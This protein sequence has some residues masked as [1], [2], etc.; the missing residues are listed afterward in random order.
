[1][2]IHTEDRVRVFLEFFERHTLQGQPIKGT[3]DE[4]P[5]PRIVRTEGGEFLLAERSIIFAGRFMFS[6]Y[7]TAAIWGKCR[8]A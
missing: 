3:P 1:M 6:R 2:R 8:K 7:S 4:V 5:Q